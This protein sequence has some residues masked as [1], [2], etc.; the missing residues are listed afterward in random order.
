MKD[1]MELKEKQRNEDL[2]LEL[3]DQSIEHSIDTQFENL[4]I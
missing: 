3:K 4:S 1:K 2:G